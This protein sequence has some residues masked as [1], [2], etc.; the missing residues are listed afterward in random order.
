MIVP[1]GLE[2]ILSVDPEVMHGD[3]CFTGTR[4]PLT[5]LLDNLTEGMGIDDFVQYYPSVSRSQ[6]EAIV[7]WEHDKIRRA[8]GLQQAS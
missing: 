1:Q 8:A 5:V 6:V 2:E 3:L 7:L 4:V